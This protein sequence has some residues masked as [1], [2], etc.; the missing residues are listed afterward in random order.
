MK[1][2]HYLHVRDHF[3]LDS[4]HWFN[5]PKVTDALINTN[6]LRIRPSIDGTHTIYD[7]EYKTHV[8]VCVP[9][10]ELAEEILQYI[11]DT[12]IMFI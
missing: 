5:Q 1:R 8:V 9:S 4:F 3:K 7:D 11:K 12:E 10:E 2:E 6:K